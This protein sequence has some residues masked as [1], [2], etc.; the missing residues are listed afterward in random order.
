MLPGDRGVFNYCNLFRRRVDM[1]GDVIIDAF[2]RR[3]VVFGGLIS[4][5]LSF[6]L[7]VVDDG[8][9]HRPRLQG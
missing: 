9:D 2:M 7:Q 3:R 4:A 6:Q 5:D 1:S 8:V